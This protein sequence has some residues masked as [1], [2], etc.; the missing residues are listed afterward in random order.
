MKTAK[1]MLDFLDEG[2][3]KEA[4]F[5]KKFKEL[6]YWDSRNTTTSVQCDNL[7]RAKAIIK[8]SGI[9]QTIKE[10]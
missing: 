9:E 10:V 6:E 5:K 4:L 2:E 8:N 1:E 3:D 7:K